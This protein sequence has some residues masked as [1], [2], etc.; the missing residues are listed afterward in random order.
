MQMDK[1]MERL[2]KERLR[3]VKRR[4]QLA[5]FIASMAV[6]VL[7]ITVGRLIQ[8]A[9]AADQDKAEFVVDGDNSSYMNMAKLSNSPQIAVTGGMPVEWTGQEFKLSAELSFAITTSEAQNEDGT[10][11][12]N[13]YYMYGSNIQIPEELCRN[14]YNHSDERGKDAFQYHFVKNEDDTYAVLVKFYDGY[15]D[16]DVQGGIEFECTGKGKVV[17]GGDVVIDVGGDVTLTI[18]GED[19]KWNKDTS[20]NY[21]ISVEKKNT[22]DNTL[23][24]DENGDKYAEYSVEIS[25]KKGTPDTVELK[26]VFSGNGMVVDT[27]RVTVTLSKNGAILSEDSF[28]YKVEQDSS[29]DKNYVLTAVLPKLEEGETYTLT[30]R[31][32]I[33]TVQMNNLQ[34]TRAEN[35]VTAES[36]D[37]N[38]G[39]SVADTSS[40]F[41][42]YTESKV[43]KKGELESGNYAIKWII[44]VNKSLDNIAG[45][46]LTDS[47]FD[48]AQN[49]QIVSDQ[50]KDGKGYE[51]QE[52]D[53]K[54]V[55]V[56]FI[57]LNNDRNNSSYTITYET[58]VESGFNKQWVSNK[59]EIDFPGGSS[60]QSGVSIPGVGTLKKELTNATKDRTNKLYTMDWKVSI[61]VSKDGIKSGTVFWDKLTS[62]NGKLMDHYMTYQQVEAA[63]KEAQTLFGDSIGSF[64]AGKLDKDGNTWWRPWDQCTSDMKF[65]LFSFRFTRNFTIPDCPDEGEILT[66]AYSSTGDYSS[67]GNTYK[68]IFIAGDAQTEAEFKYDSPSISKMDGNGNR[69]TTEVTVGKDGTLT[70]LVKVTLDE[71]STRYEVTDQMPEGVSVE[72]VSIQMKYNNADGYFD[73]PALDGTAYTVDNSNYFTQG[74]ETSSSLTENSGQQTV[75]TDIKKGSNTTGW[76]KDSC[77]YLKYVCRIKDFDSAEAGTKWTFTNYASAR[78]NHNEDTIHA[79]QTQIVTKPSSSGGSSDTPEQG[80]SELIKNGKWDNDNHKLRYTVVINPEGKDLVENCEELTLTDVLSYDR[81]SY[82]PGQF[83]W[84]AS[85]IPQSVKLYTADKNGD[86]TYQKKEPVT[87]WNWKYEENSSAPGQHYSK[88]TRTITAAVP[89]GKTLI[90]VYDYSVK[91]T[92][93]VAPDR[94]QNPSFTATNTAKLQGVSKG[95]TQT[96]DEVVYVDSGTSAYVYKNNTYVFTKVDKDNYNNLLPGAQFEMYQYAPE[97][98]DPSKTEDGY[99]PVQQFE[100]DQNGQFTIEFKNGIS[101]YNTQYYVVETKAPDGYILPEEPQKYYFYFEANKVSYPVSAKDNILQGKCLA[102]NY[103]TEYAENE[104]VPTTSITVEK[105]WVGSDGKKF[106]RKDGSIFIQIHQVDSEGNDVPYGDV[107]EIKPDEN[108]NWKITYSDLPKAQIDEYGH[109]TNKIYKYYVEE[110][111]V[112]TNHNMAGY[113]VSYNYVDGSKNETVGSGG[114]SSAI[115]SGTVEI[116]NKRNEY[117]LP[118][119]GGSGNRWLFM[120]SG[121]TLMILAGISLYYK[122]TKQIYNKEELQ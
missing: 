110:T 106:D 95:E 119:T 25:S 51:I 23:K 93:V 11:Q 43:E 102:D 63:F 34:K 112:D 96:K 62:A 97:S 87:D 113:E 8:P 105:N 41:V 99:V 39:E 38:T 83:D 4:R 32:Y 117:V 104:A 103:F 73:Y 56:K 9:S 115:E 120:L 21:D 89:D 118:S 82:Y 35:T 69:E 14:W 98:T 109:L 29:N 68:N 7:G 45:H 79:E 55:S 58:P 27:D 49:F 88:E 91:A 64:E 31:Y 60:S 92:E 116:T 24:T 75:I 36:T 90:L 18:S 76:T 13:F 100:T 108:G 101:K 57:A 17:E 28:T 16:S 84:Q 81:R 26:D 5:I 86:G 59:A 61:G 67:G 1:D 30:Y 47:M 78:S 72:K 42:E 52:Q 2:G 6:I 77:I 66:L 94:G 107:R 22:T 74:I 48:R 71:D 33:D 65:N 121:F 111:G 122:K 19:V 70:W 37:K 46:T 12:N 3:R 85:L 54:I 20:L 53:G 15:I 10:A 114:K 80:S 50:D 40:S 44:Y